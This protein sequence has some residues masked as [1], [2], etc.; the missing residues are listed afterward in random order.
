[1]QRFH[2]SDHTY[3]H[4]YNIHTHVRWNDCNDFTCP[5]THMYTIYNVHT[6]V[7]WNDCDSFTR[8]MIMRCIRPDKLVPAVMLYVSKEM[9]QKFIEPP[10]FDLSVSTCL[11]VCVYICLS[12]K[13]L[14]L[15]VYLSVCLFTCLSFQRP[16]LTEYLSVC[17]SFYLSVLSTTKSDCVSVCLSVFLLVC[18][19]N[20]QV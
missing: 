10:P 2:V 20:D 7:R 1:L 6:H 8:L 3:I 15:T 14:S 19:F 5:T 9:G 4:I 12:F 17:R 11:S 18:L 13:R 16:S